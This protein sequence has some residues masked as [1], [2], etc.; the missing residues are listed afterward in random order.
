[1]TREVGPAAPPREVAAPGDGAGRGTIAGYTV[2][3]GESRRGVALVDLADGR[4]CMV[5]TDAPAVVDAF[6]A[7]ECCGRA[8]DVSGGELRRLER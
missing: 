3:H 2:V 5:G 7:E 4:R 8:V 6:E 1:M